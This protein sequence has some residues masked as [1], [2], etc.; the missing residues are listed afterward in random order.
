MKY[1]ALLIV[2]VTVGI[3]SCDP[4]YKCNEVDTLQVFDDL[5]NLDSIV[6][7]A[8]KITAT[9]VAFDTLFNEM[10]IFIN[11]D[12]EYQA[13]KQRAINN[14]CSTC[15]FPNIDFSRHTLIGRYFEIGCSEFATQRFVAT[16]DS[17]FAFYNKFIN[18]NQ[19]AF[20]NC[21]NEAYNWLLVPKI[22]SIDQIDFF[23]GQFYYECNC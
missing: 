16:S 1:I 8:D 9:D 21:P 10:K 11:S 4:F 14:G 12:A 6:Y 2:L 13:M 18:Q 23:Y 17:T 22:Q 7:M 20:S 3:Y 15:V 19:C 5:R